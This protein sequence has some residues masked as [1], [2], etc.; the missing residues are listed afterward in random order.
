V[1]QV[2]PVERFDAIQHAQCGGHRLPERHRPSRQAR[3][4]RLSLEQFHRQEQLAVRFADLVQLTDGGMVQAGRRPCFAD[5][6][7]ASRGLVRR[8]A[9]HLDRDRAPEALVARRIDDAHAAFAESAGNCVMA[10]GLPHRM[11]V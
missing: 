7:L 4:E 2:L 10:D 8:G 9:D 11:R 1:H 3:R 6:P 5:Q